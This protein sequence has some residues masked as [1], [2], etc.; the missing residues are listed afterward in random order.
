MIAAQAG[1]PEP[2][3][4]PIP[5]H[6]SL[7]GHL[8][9]SADPNPAAPVVMIQIPQQLLTTTLATIVPGHGDRRYHQYD[10]S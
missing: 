6:A 7:N 8:R 2:R 4:R 10:Y 5:L 9:S 3:W 1:I